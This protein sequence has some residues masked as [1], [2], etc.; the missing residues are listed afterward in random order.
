MDSVIQNPFDGYGH[1]IRRHQFIGR[2]QALQSIK[3][4][5]VSASEPGNLAIIGDHRIGKSS[6]AYAGI[7]ERRDELLKHG[8][9]PIWVNIATYDNQADFFRSL[10]STAH[11]ELEERGLLNDTINRVRSQ[12]AEASFTWAET[13]EYIQRYFKKVRQSGIWIIFI[14]DEFDHARILFKDSVSGF[15]QLRSLSYDDPEGRVTFVTTSRRTIREIEEQTHSIS[16]FDGIFSKE[17]LGIFNAEDMQ[18]FYSTMGK[19]RLQLTDAMRDQIEN[20]CGGHPYLLTSL[21]Y[22]IVADWL[23]GK[24]IEIDKLMIELSPSFLT[25]YDRMTKLL[26][27]DGRLIKLLQIL[28]GPRVDVTQADVDDFL[29]YGLLKVAPDGSYQ[30]FST[31]FQSYLRLIER[32]S[33]LWPIWKQTEIAIREH[34]TEKMTQKYASKDWV[35][36]LEREKP[37]LK[38]L[39]DR[40][41]EAQIKE[42]RSFGARASSNLIDFTYPSDLFEIIFSDWGLFSPALGKD[43][44]YWEDRRQFLSRIRNPLAHNRDFVLQE[45]ERLIA[46][47]Y[48]KEILSCLNSN[49]D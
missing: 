7:M 32:N 47:G 10:V 35:V 12:V 11:M 38:T 17:Y 27:E 25:Q 4:R 19:T 44:N 24:A 40:C 42:Q 15:Q 20:Y 5:V 21:G 49:L 43:K 14:L 41:R 48:C 18:Q 22:R 8:R 45:H 13:F 16:T 1:I 26:N 30:T 29:R 33:E 28:F 46:E 6:L 34:I 37:K 39:F 9:I 3:D 2:T 31:H 36:E 23:L